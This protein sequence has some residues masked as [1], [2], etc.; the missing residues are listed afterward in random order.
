MDVLYLINKTCNAKCAHCYLEYKGDKMF[1]KA[2][3][4][5]EALVSSGHK[6]TLL[7]SELVPNA[8]LHNEK[9]IEL[10]GIAGQ[11]WIFTNGITISK[12]PAV[13]TILRDNGIKTIEFSMHSGLEDIFGCV[14][15][16]TVRD[17]IEHA[18]SR[19]FEVITG[20]I[21][22]KRNYTKIDSI[23]STAKSIGSDEVEFI[24]FLPVGSARSM[25]HLMLDSYELDCAV[26]LISK[27]REHYAKDE[28]S[29]KRF[30]NLKPRYCPAGKEV[31]AVTPDNSIYPCQFMLGSSN[32]IGRLEN[33]ELNFEEFPVAD[34]KEGCA[35]YLHCIGKV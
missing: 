11:D 28:L 15:E 7:G 12:N 26:K 20:T 21:L 18:I 33:N 34:R 27:A 3:T 10:F 32:K 30:G 13:L 17:S 5:V 9:Y 29:I 25:K 16:K 2:K 35:A 1:G 6:V 24:N 8:D 31:V 23:C 14:G 22:C 4:E 19:D